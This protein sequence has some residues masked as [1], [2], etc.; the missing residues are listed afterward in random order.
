MKT[1]QIIFAD[2]GNISCRERKPLSLDTAAAAAFEHNGD[3]AGIYAVIVGPGK[4]FTRCF[5]RI[6]D[7]E[8]LAF[9]HR[10]HTLSPFLFHAS[11]ILPLYVNVNLHKGVIHFKYSVYLIP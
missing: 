5:Y 3:N 7:F 6:G 1:S 10:P 2:D 8:A 11:I 9:K 4:M